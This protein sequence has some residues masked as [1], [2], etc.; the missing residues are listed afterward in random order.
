MKAWTSGSVAGTGTFRCTQCDTAVSLDAADELPSCPNCG[1]TE[2][3]RTSLFTTAQ[4]AVLEIAAARGGG[5][6]VAG[7]GAG[8]PA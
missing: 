5:P 1:G 8:R 2:F 6:L 7:P 3:V 4:Q